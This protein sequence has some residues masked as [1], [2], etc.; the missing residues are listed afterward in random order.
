VRRAEAQV[1]DAAMR[2]LVEH[3]EE[4]ARELE[5]AEAKARAQRAALRS[6]ANLWVRDAGRPQPIQVGPKVRWV[7][8]DGDY[9][10]PEG[11]T[12]LRA[13][14]AHQLGHVLPPEQLPPD[15]STILARLLIDPEAP[16]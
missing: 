1:R 16:L 3:G 4:M 15:W 9:Q 13:Q 14:R 8:T 11:I 6:L 7:L 10:Q 5:A 12:G 2:L